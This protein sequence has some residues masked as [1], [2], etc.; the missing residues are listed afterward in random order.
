VRCRLGADRN[1]ELN[2]EDVVRGLGFTELAKSG[3]VTIRWRTVR[4]YLL[5]FGIA[6]CCDDAKTLEYI[7]E[8][9]FYKLCFK[10]K[11]EIARAFQDKVTDEILPAI[12]KH[13]AYL[14]PAKIE[15]VLLN[16]DTIIK[17]AN[18]L[19]VER[20]K[21]LFLEAQIEQDKPKVV[22]AEAITHSMANAV[23][24]GD[25]SKILKT[26]GI[27]IGQNRLC[28]WLRENNYLMSRGSS[29][30]M[31]TQRA[32]ELGLFIVNEQLVVNLDGTITD[33]FTV[34]ITGKGQQYF[35]NKFLAEG[36]MSYR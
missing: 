18:D 27:D 30:N 6:T 10:A 12:R 15:E 22:F 9:I 32:M 35:V 17:L 25:L 28:K 5:D 7:P 13:G 2:L 1:P 31:P 23:M 16:P 3:N 19:K 34:R 20:E 8:N 11:N 36:G 4:G 26:N 14:T 33:K 21:C 24:I 29:Y